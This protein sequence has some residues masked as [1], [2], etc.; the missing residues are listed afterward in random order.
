MSL[1]YYITDFTNEIKD[2]ENKIE[3]QKLK[4]EIY[5]SLKLKFLNFIKV[6]NV[7]IKQMRKDTKGLYEGYELNELV[8]IK[9]FKHNEQIYNGYNINVG[10]II[11][12]H[13]ISYNDRMIFKIN[14]IELDNKDDIIVSRL[15]SD[16]KYILNN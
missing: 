2:L 11:P 16:K 3:K 8:I 1:Q 12:I 10:D 4:R 7:L 13:A 6:N 5:L 9:E 14:G 15:Y